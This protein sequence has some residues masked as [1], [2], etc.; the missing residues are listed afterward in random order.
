MHVSRVILL[1]LLLGTSCGIARAQ[2][3]LR[4]TSELD[5]NGDFS[6]KMVEGIDRFL[7]RETEEA[8]EERQQFW[9]RDVSS[10][11]AYEQCVAPNRARLKEILGVVDERVAIEAIEFVA[12]T[13]HGDG[14]VGET[15]SFRIWAVRWPVLE[16]VHGEGL[17]LRPKEKAR[18]WVIPL[19]DADQTPE[20]LAGLELGIGHRQQFAR[21][22]AEAG[23]EVFV[24]VLVNR[25]DRFSGNAELGRFT[26]QPHREWI[27]R[28][29]Y[30]M[31]RHIIGYEVQKVLALVD[32]ITTHATTG[33][34]GEPGRIGVAGYG[35]GGLLALHAAA[36]DP[37]IDSA[38][39]SGYF[40]ARERLWQEPIYR[41]VFGL[42]RQ[43]GDAEL[44]GLVAPR[45]LVVEYSEHPAVKGPPAPRQGRHGAAP[46]GIRTPERWEVEEELFRAMHFLPPEQQGAF[47]MVY[48]NEGNLVGPGSDRA[49]DLFCEGLGVAMRFMDVQG[50]L[51]EAKWK[52]DSGQRQERQV[53]E[54]VEFTQGLVQKA[55]RFRN[56]QFW[57]A[58]KAKGPEEWSAASGEWKDQLWE[59]VLGKIENPYL[60][61]NPRS[62]KVHETAAYTGYEV[63]VDVWPDVFAW[64]ILLVP[65]DLAA[66]E[67]RPVVVCQHGLEGVPGDTISGE[68]TPGYR[69]Y[70][71]F[72]ARLAERGFVTFSPHNPY[73]GEDRFRVLQRKA[74]PLGWSLFSV[75][76]GQH[77]QLL[78]WLGSLEMVD[79][80]RIGFYGLSYGGK[81]AMR[82]PAILGGYCLSICSADFNDW[83]RKN[84]TVDSPY[85]YLFTGE[86]EMPEFNLGWTFNYGEMAA[87]IAPRP[88][89][90]ERGH[91]DG[92]APDEWVAYE[93]A[94]VRRHYATLGVPERT[95]IEFFDGPH[96][97]HGVG[98]FEFLHQHLA[99]PA[100]A[101][102]H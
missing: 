84:V 49:L 102:S 38:L 98:T 88:F 61:L 17:W 35:E 26:N 75:I 37:R 14:C 39:V 100:P 18:G 5:W 9:N 21:R 12:S 94:K 99:W 2:A 101:E 67:K 80:N 77:E 25:S 13:R 97:I 81:T 54:L 79:P 48:G 43:F 1:L 45:R 36:L 53:T 15:E 28:Q 8:K 82:V 20:M 3:L 59:N 51:P 33:A 52:V 78:K 86:Y 76:L 85:S 66:R 7:T 50:E 44:A 92:V 65:N 40:G 34:A 83:I 23:F 10:R 24:P 55:E 63:V 60:P 89:M 56:R 27:Y 64:G 6:A 30:E 29:A 62:R 91:H 58:A 72:A 41:N 32:W 19:P 69:A 16:G 68:G 47:Q 31:G 74:N 73:R 46:G 90:V 96:T 11:E 71:S 95:R 93:Y 70:K 4:G 57:G 22:L 42:L 87:L